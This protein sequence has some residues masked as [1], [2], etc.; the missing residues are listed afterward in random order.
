[1]PYEV[2]DLTDLAWKL[3]ARST[4]DK[5][6]W[7]DLCKGRSKAKH[8]GV[9]EFFEMR[10]F[11]LGEEEESSALGSSNDNKR[12]ESLKDEGAH[13]EA[14]PARRLK[15]DISAEPAASEAS[16]LGKVVPPMLPSSFP[17]EGTSR[18][19]SSPPVEGT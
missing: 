19:S 18:E 14:S 4:Y 11:P 17:V 12:N 3:A 16:S 10:P 13:S 8:H 5:R 6:K 2:P 7:R 15:E 1:M 9:G